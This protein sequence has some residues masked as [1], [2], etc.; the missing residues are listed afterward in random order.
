MVGNY[1][2]IR[3][4]GYGW[5]NGGSI[6]FVIIRPGVAEPERRQH[7]QGGRFGSAIVYR[8]RHQ[9]IRR[10]SFRIFDKHIEIAVVVE[11]T[12]VD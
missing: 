7:V 2:L 10:T 3:F 6:R 4:Q 8:N 1:S 9:Y 5:P 12:R 11:D